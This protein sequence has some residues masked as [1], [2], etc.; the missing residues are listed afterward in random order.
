VAGEDHDWANNCLNGLAA[1]VWS[2]AL[3]I[4]GVVLSLILHVTNTATP[5]LFT[6]AFVPAAI[7]FYGGL[8]ACAIGAFPLTSMDPR[9][10][11]TEEILSPRRVARWGMLTL[12]LVVTVIYS[13]RFLWPVAQ[14]VGIRMLHVAVITGILAV[15]MSASLRHLAS[16][17][18]RTGRD[19]LVKEA[20][21]IERRLRWLI[22][23]TG[24][25]L[26]PPMAL[27]RDNSLRGFIGCAAMIM[28]IG[29]F[30]SA[31][32]LAV[33]MGRARQEFRECLKQSRSFGHGP[34]ASDPS[35]AAH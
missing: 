11:L 13:L 18:A 15:L 23:V 30:S 29:L 10:T 27:G 35:A 24:A 25:L 12:L 21:A 26:L 6:I 4:I 5:V 22:P 1:C 32:H 7:G 17:L 34:G 14:P 2:V 16:L 8:L 20:R 28:I 19:D 31:V 3:A 33:I 9:S